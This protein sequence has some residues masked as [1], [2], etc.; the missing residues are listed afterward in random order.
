VPEQGPPQGYIRAALDLEPIEAPLVWT[1]QLL[2]ALTFGGGLIAL[3]ATY[4]MVGRIVHPLARL[5]EGAQA[6][7]AGDD[8]HPVYVESSDELGMLGGA[9]NHMQR[10]LSSRLGQLREN[11]ERLATFLGSMV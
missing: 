8:Q 7:A 10:E 9:F 2:M 4:F 6:I 1:E 5:T 11:S 3:G